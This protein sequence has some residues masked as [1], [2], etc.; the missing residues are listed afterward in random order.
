MRVSAFKAVGGYESL[1]EKYQNSSAP[2][3]SLIDQNDNNSKYCNEVPEDFMHLLRS[4]VPG[5]SDLPWTGVIFGLSISN[6][7]YWCTDQVNISLYQHLAFN[8]L[9]F[10]CLKIYYFN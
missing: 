1:L 2:N 9:V 10:V 4:A 7:W 3:R 6:I 8:I 5:E